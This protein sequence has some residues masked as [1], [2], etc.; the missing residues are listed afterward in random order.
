MLAATSG[1]FS[2]NLMT[3]TPYV[4]MLTIMTGLRGFWNGSGG[5]GRGTPG[6]C[7]LEH[8]FFRE[9]EEAREILLIE[10]NH[11]E[12]RIGEVSV[13][14]SVHRRIRD[15]EAFC[16]DQHGIALVHLN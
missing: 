1:H 7:W 4:W 13:R 8:E 16:A 10:W 5:A 11:A 14:T 12:A 3:V 2:L 9:L 15:V 6:P